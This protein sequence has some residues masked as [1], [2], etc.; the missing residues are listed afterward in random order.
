MSTPESLDVREPKQD[1][2]SYFV[3]DWVEVR[4]KEEILATLD[5][6]GKLEGLPFMPEMFAFCGKRLRVHKRAHKTCDTVNDYKGRKMKD[7]VHLEGVHCDGKA[8]G[9]CEASCTVFWKT[10]WLRPLD[11]SGALLVSIDTGAYTGTVSQGKGCA[12]FD[13]VAATQ[14]PASAGGTSNSSPVYSCQATRLPEYT[15]FLPWWQPWQYVEDYRSGNV[16]LSRIAK[17]FAYRAYRRYF[18]NLGIGLG[19]PLKWLYNIVQSLRGGVPYP[20]V[21]G[22][23]PPGTRTPTLTLDLQPGEWV[24]VKSVDEIL[25]TCEPNKTTN[26]GMTF[27]PEMVPYCGGTYQVVKR[28]TKLINEKTGVMQEM[29][30]PCIILDEVVCQAR[31]SQCR[32]FCPRA[33][34]PYW[35]EIWLERVAGPTTAAETTTTSELIRVENLAA[36]AERVQR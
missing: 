29:K 10:A 15:E 14:K 11:R 34:Y 30:Y 31:Y 20:S 26:R 9:G 27:D 8:H 13:V 21:S 25:A 16:G 23:L 32:L 7:A 22:T 19:R 35:R 18:V 17:S 4:S 3:G 33:L 36:E 2:H 6:D 5:K 28:V 12:E 24:R 1:S